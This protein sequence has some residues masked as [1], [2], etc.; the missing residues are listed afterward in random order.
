MQLPDDY[1]IPRQA[2]ALAARAGGWAL[3]ERAAPPAPPAP[4][5]PAVWWERREAY[6]ARWNAWCGFL[7]A[8]EKTALAAHARWG[9]ETSSPLWLVQ[10]VAVDARHPD[11]SDGRPS[12][13]TARRS[14]SSCSSR[15]MMVLPDQVVGVRLR[16]LPESPNHR[17]RRGWDR[18]KCTAAGAALPWRRCSSAKLRGADMLGV[19]LALVM[20][21]AGWRP[22][23]AKP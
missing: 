20:E 15:F 14:A 6:N 8:Q 3:P 12:S 1:V 11:P 18:G 19:G 17:G 2:P 5:L 9:A 7:S 13:D 21:E 23:V 22:T 10:L 4:E 16:H